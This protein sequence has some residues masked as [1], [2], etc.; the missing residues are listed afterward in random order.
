MILLLHPSKLRNFLE[1]DCLGRILYY[2]FVQLI[3]LTSTV[4]F[5]FIADNSSHPT[6]GSEPGS[7]IDV[8]DY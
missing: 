5:V 2:I 8:Y 6:P 3:F 7:R 1:Y 4:F